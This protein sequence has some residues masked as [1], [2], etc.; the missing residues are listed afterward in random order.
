[1]H[2]AKKKKYM[3][4]IFFAECHNKI[5]GK[6]YLCLVLNF[7]LGKKAPYVASRHAMDQLLSSA[8]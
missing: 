8:L 4:N 7:T 1:M 5:L 6:D 3:N 2:S